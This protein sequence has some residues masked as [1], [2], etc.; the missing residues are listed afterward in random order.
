[1][2]EVY[3]KHG[4]LLDR[5]PTFSEAANKLNDW[6]Q[7]KFVVCAGW[8]STV[9]AVKDEKDASGGLEGESDETIHA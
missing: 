1:M 6:P 4:Y 3:S 5:F 8:V 2:Y 9:A 7:A